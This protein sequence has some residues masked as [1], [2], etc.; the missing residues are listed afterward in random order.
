MTLVFKS[1]KLSLNATKSRSLK[2]LKIFQRS[3]RCR[4]YKPKQRYKDRLFRVLERRHPSIC[5][6]E[7][8]KKG[9]GGGERVREAKR[10]REMER[11]KG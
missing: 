5:E 4:N 6:A 11:D 9:G 3:V 7:R 2:L 10:V 8:E 1:P